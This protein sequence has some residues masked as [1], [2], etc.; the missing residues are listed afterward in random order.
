MATI[1]SAEKVPKKRPQPKGGSR[2][3]RPNKISADLKAMVFGALEKKGGQ[4]FLEK[5]MD[6][7][8]VAFMSLLGKF[9]PKDVN[10]GGQADNPLSIKKIEIVVVDPK[11]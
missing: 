7:N 10:I 5:Q 11:A 6:E 8:P 2:K 9:V 3:G 1:Q 4:K